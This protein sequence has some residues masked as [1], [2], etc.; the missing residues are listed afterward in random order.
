MANP[1]WCSAVTGN[2]VWIHG[3]FNGGEWND[4]SPASLFEDF[5]LSHPG[6]AGEQVE[7]NAGYIACLEK[8]QHT[9]I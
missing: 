5:L 3:V 9:L 2:I 4:F 1:N 7:A 6:G 8:P